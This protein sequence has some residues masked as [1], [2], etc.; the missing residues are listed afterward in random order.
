MAISVHKSDLVFLIHGDALEA[1][2][3]LPPESVNCCV[4]SPPYWGLR[5]YG[6]GE[7][8]DGDPDCDHRA[9][10]ERR[11]IPHGDGRQNDSYADERHT[12][13][14]AGA[15][16]RTTC[17]K[18]G[19]RRIDQQIG[20]E[21]TPEEWVDR[22]V[23]VFGEVR[24]VLRK[25]GTLWLNVGDCYASG[26]R[27][28]NPGNTSTLGGSRDNQEQSMVQRSIA[29]PAGLKPKDLIGL[30]WLLAFALRA[31]GWWLRSD[32]IWCLSGGAKVYAQ[33]QKGEMPMTIKDLVRLD[34]ATVKLWN[35]EKWT[36]CLGW[37]ESP[38]PNESIEIELRSGEKIG[39]TPRHAWS[40]QRG[41][42]WADE[43]VP[44]DVIRRC[45]LPEPSNPHSPVL[46]GQDVAWFLGIYLAEGSRDDRGRIQIA[47]HIDEAGQRIDSIRPISEAFG[48]T[49]RGY[50]VKGDAA[51]IVV[52]CPPLAAI[53]DQYIRG[54]SAKT[55]GIKVRAWKHS[56][57]WLSAL[58]AGYLAGDGSDRGGGR[59]RLGFTRNDS[60][61]DD[62]RTIA[63]RLGHTLTLKIATTEGFGQTWPIYRGEICLT[64][65]GHHN[66][67]D[68]GEIVKIGTSRDRKFWHIGVE[69]EPH[70]FALASGLLTHN[71]K[72]NPMPESVTD[73]PTKSHEYLFLLTK[74]ERYHYDADAIKTPGKAPTK[75]PDGWATH[76]GGHGSFHKDGREKGQPVERK[77]QNPEETGG[78]GR[79]F[80]GH[81]GNRRPD[82]TVYGDGYANA[83]T[84]W[85]IPT[86]P[87]PQAHFATFP[88][89]LVEPCILA[90]CPPGGTV[91]DPF[92]G[93]GTTG[94][95][96]VRHER[97]FVGIDLNREY[98]DEIAQPR[99]TREENKDRQPGL[100]WAD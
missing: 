88:E 52:N 27:G 18:C 48:G 50:T 77:H 58:L 76:A 15:L 92:C 17:K 24:R 45:R 91:L 19:A 20:L 75:M 57:A 95:V 28:G 42:V 4:T 83:R 99:I 3:A 70:L 47:S 9:V 1:L 40:T 74:A 63:A 7:W 29:P 61:A 36:Q 2:G 37:N 16:Y 71:S 41:N 56:D 80:K 49:A 90:G 67:K 96:A 64:R 85:T 22:M 55:K 81:T 86:Q 12:I 35:G 100:P 8:V 84:V 68:R 23:E 44:G 46:I 97:H 31:D 94:V 69:D 78:A 43:L 82:G 38:R 6:T 13:P 66:E 5:D 25:D 14:G 73:R 39:C 65:S 62:L 11:Q 98:L 30:P 26:G 87:M 54:R 93:S 89:K 33:T 72:S 32:I 59:W 51:V 79:G 60:L 21:G 10:G 34:P 53:V